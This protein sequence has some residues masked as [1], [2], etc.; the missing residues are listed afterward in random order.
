MNRIKEQTLSILKPDATRRHITGAI[1]S[2]LEAGGMHIVAQKR[3]RLTKEEAAAFYAV[4]AHQAFFDE[5]C[6]VMSSGPVV[7]QVLERE[8]AVAHHRALMG[9]TNPRDAAEGTVRQKF[10]LSISENTVHGSDS[11][12]NAQ[13]EIQFFF[14]QKDIMEGRA[15]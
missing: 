4:H 5:L 1:N 2:I 9:S 11:I 8:N 13:T 7:V 15:S 10:G 3:L 14:S 12:E 6:T